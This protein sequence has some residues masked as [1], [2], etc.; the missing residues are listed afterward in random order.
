MKKK[1][2]ST[3]LVLVMTISVFSVAAAAS[4]SMSNF[5]KARTYNNGQFS[6]VTESAWYGTGQ[7]GVI[8]TAFEYGLMN[9]NSAT[10]FNPAGNISVAESLAVAA[11]VHSIYNGGNGD[12]TQG[13]PWYQV[14]VDYARANGINISDDFTNYTRAATRAEMAYIFARS[15]PTAQFTSQNTVSSLPDVSADTPHSESI[16]TLYRAGVLTGSDADGTFNPGNN[17]NR[18]EAAAI[19]SRII[20]PDT[21]VSGKTYGGDSGFTGQVTDRQH[22]LSNGQTGKYTGNLVNGEADDVNGKFVYDSGYI[23]TGGFKG[24]NISGQGTM[25]YPSGGEYVGEFKN[26]LRDG[27]GT[28]S[29]ADNGR[30]Y[31]GGWKDGKQDGQGTVYNADGT[32]YQQGQWKDGSFVSSSSFT[33]QVTDQQHSLSNGQPGK[34]TGAL[35]N[36]EAEDVNGKFVYDSGYIYTGGFKGNNIDGQGTMLFPA[37]DEYVGEFKNGLR[38]GQ[39]TYTFAASGSKYVGGWK[40]NNRDGQGTVYN[41]DGTIYQQGHWRDGSFVS[42]SSFTGQVTDQQHSLSNGQPGKYTGSLVN[43]EAEDVNG[44][45]VYD[46]GYIYTGGF[47]GNNID[48]QGTMIF[49]AGDEYVGEFKNGLRDGQGTYTFAASGSKYVG[50]WKNNNRDG[51]GTVY[52][53]DGTIYQQ[54]Q[55]KDGTFIGG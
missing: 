52:N 2:I 35:V 44:K 36:G 24:N 41:A 30:R 18:A 51:Q 39:G 46:S 47:K 27:Q 8:A 29:Y 22:S 4:P 25:I 23:Y 37:G 33:G 34:Y 10:T 17:I 19:I 14:Y 15:I 54:G 50:G 21:R 32:I 16:L 20:L 26:G 48:G 31:V 45:F 5:I 12:F 1:I 11:R 42:S 38:D 9:G 7:Q 28:Y 55:W 40:N 43:G 53:A 13:S 6:D 49:P 3:A